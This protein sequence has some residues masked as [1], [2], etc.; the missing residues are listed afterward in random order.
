M[1]DIRAT[2]CLG[3]VF[4]GCVLPTAGCTGDRMT[5]LPSVMP[6]PAPLEARGYDRH[7]PFPDEAAGPETFTRPRGFTEPRSGTQRE[8]DRLLRSGYRLPGGGTQTVVGPAYEL[9]ATAVR[10]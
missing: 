1:G 2:T 9:P 10:P 5:Q 4:L 6:R 8:Q 3:V 7:D